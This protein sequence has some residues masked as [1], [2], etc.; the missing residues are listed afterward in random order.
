MKTLCKGIWV[1]ATMTVPGVSG[2]T[3]AMIM[4]VYSRLMDSVNNILKKPWESIKFLLQF[5]IGGIVGVVLFARFI[6]TLLED[7][8]WGIPLQFFFVGAVAGGV[9]LIFHEAGIKKFSYKLILYPVIGI[10][11]VSL[12][13]LLP[14]GIFSGSEGI[15][16]ILLQFV[17]GIVIAVALVLPGISASQMLCT[18]GIY[19]TV[20]LNISN[21]H[22]LSL[23]P[24]AI[25]VFVGI[26][27]S[28][29]VIG[30]LLERFPL[31]TYLIILGFVAGSVWE[32]LPKGTIGNPI[33]CVIGVV[34]GACLLYLMSRMEIKG[35]IKNE[36][37][38]QL[39]S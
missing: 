31:E 20:M 14:D 34:I 10:L 32:L 17:G 30:K 22:I 2:G 1:G 13:S 39:S 29:G 12:L 18:L 5:G 9:P 19:E 37:F 8:V 16:G 4:G 33:L 35:K 28:T 27:L 15:S 6:T 25:G 36:S 11:L 24:L 21:F 26:F 38:T 3:M 23:L 7:A